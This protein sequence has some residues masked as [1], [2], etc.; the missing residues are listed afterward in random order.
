M[1]IVSSTLGMRVCPEVLEGRN[2]GQAHLLSE[3]PSEWLRE[4]AE[5]P[6]VTILELL[7]HDADTACLRECGEGSTVEAALLGDIF[8]RGMGA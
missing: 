7:P 4:R 6:A 8:E 1:K 5:A 2:D 3:Q